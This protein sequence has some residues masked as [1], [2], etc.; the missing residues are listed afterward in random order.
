MDS[1]KFDSLVKTLVDSAPRRRVR[2][3]YR[4]KSLWRSH[5]RHG[6]PGAPRRGRVAVQT[7]VRRVRVARWNLCGHDGNARKCGCARPP[8]CR[9]SSQC[10]DAQSLQVHGRCL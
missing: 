9:N 1:Q 4:G 10:R 7:T 2:Q 8:P 3:G 5:R 6:S